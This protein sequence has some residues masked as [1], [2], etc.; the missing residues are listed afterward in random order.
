MTGEPDDEG[1]PSPADL[2]LLFGA[3]EQAVEADRVNWAVLDFFDRCPRPCWIRKRVS[4]DGFK[5]V[6]INRAFEVALGVSAI[7]ATTKD[8][9]SIWPKAI[10][11][12]GLEYDRQVLKTGRAVAYIGTDGHRTLS[13]HK[14]PVLDRAGEIIAVCGMAELL[15]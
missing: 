14:W 6:R 1:A 12:A 5:L 2:H 9:Y 4:E 10:A 15:T 8:T 7:E 13:I 11:E 3:F